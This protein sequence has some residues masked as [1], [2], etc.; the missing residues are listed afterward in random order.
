[1]NSP[2]RIRNGYY[3]VNFM[4]PNGLWFYTD[5]QEAKSGAEQRTRETRSTHLILSFVGECSLVPVPT[6][7]QWKCAL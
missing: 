5:L 3:V 4:S 7:V 2:E 6:Q 1:M